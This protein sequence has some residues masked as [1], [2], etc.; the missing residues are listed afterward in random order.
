MKIHAPNAR[1][2]ARQDWTLGLATFHIALDGGPT[3]L[4]EPG[5]FTN[6]ALPA[7]PRW[8]P[9]TGAAIKR[10]YSIASSPGAPSFEFFVR[11]V[12]QGALTPKLFALPLGAPVYVD[13]R[14]AGHFTL[15]GAPAAED[16]VLVGTGTGIA[17]YRPMIL[18]PRTRERY[19]RVLLFY[20][21]RTRPDLGYVDEFAAL[22]AR[23]PDR[24]LFL[25]SLTREPVDSPWT[26]LRGR[27][28]HLLTAE[29]YL[30][31][32]G[33]PLTPE[34]CQV[35]LCGNPQMILEVQGQLE[36]LGFRKHRKREPGQLHIEKYW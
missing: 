19:G 36:A 22:A 31:L 1:L 15:E 34:R 4:F 3:P 13:P 23:E 21:D 11:L 7:G 12:E 30:T 16:L 14:V 27:V 2:V 17:P 6:L 5:Q 9:E 32:T 24:F 33:A 35:F 20:T 26:G 29:R 28:Q 10:A 18:D 8:D 25:P